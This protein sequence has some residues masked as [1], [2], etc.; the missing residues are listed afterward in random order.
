MPW[1]G[2]VLCVAAG[3]AVGGFIGVGW[4]CWRFADGMDRAFGYR[5]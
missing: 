5:P 3:I 2:V 4:I 1:W